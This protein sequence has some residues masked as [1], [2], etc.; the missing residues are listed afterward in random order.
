MFLDA[1]PDFTIGIISGQEDLN[2]Y[3]I[4]NFVP[5]PQN[6]NPLSPDSG[7]KTQIESPDNLLLNIIFSD[8][9]N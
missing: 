9:Y 1:S 2:S 4:E 6:L 7:S 8:T 5:I 3:V